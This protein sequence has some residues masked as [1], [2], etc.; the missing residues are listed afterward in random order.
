MRRWRG[1]RR[2]RDCAAAI[3]DDL[4]KLGKKVLQI[5]R[6]MDIRIM[7]KESMIQRPVPHMTRV[8]TT[9]PRLHT[10]TTSVTETSLLGDM[11]EFFSR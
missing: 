5:D 8:H 2:S 11:D 10:Q 1:S 6:D 7:E 9:M 4:T 3:D